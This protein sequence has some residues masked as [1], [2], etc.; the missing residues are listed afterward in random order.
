MKPSRYL[1]I[2]TS[3][4]LLLAVGLL[5]LRGFGVGLPA[6]ITQGFWACLALLVFVAVLDG[7]YSRKMPIAQVIRKFPHNFFVG[8]THQIAL[9]I[10]HNHATPWVI[11]LYDHYPN[12][13]R[14][15]DLPQT[16]KLM[17]GKVATIFYEVTPSVR[18]DDQFG[19][20]EQMFFS[21]LGL[22]H[23][24]KK[25]E[26]TKPVKVLPDFAQIMGAGITN[27]ERWMNLLGAKK[28]PRKGLGQDFHQLREY[29][30]EDTFRQIDW[31][32]TARKQSLVSREY[33][34]ERDQQIVFL[35]DCGRNMRAKDG[36]VSH[37]DCALNAMLLLTYTA[38]RHGDSVGVLT[39]SNE[40]PRFIRPG[41]G[42]AQLGHI[43][44]GL[45][46]VVPTTRTSDYA[47]AA[48][49][50]LSQQRRRALVIVLTNL[51]NEGEMELL[52]SLKHISRRHRLLI[53]SLKEEVLDRVSQTPVHDFDGAL[54]YAGA[55]S[56]L[57]DMNALYQ[58][59]HTHK[60]PFMSTHPR[61][62][63]GELISQ[64][65]KFKRDGL[66]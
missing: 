60:V 2:C 18:G 46:D 11:T 49:V 35:L 24:I 6:L 23:I 20:I 44:H 55:I 56:Y 7:Y 42:T 65:L 25:Q 64:Y 41:K 59:L 66:W 63:G 15:T 62:F 53:A 22:W 39:F 3:V 61:E 33:Q 4:L 29:R 27:L 19:A 12:T 1:L 10:H 17:P 52:S 57:R 38:L 13:W 58:K 9:E 34:D 48:D 5:F 37:F 16:L 31:K 45:Y 21:R 32:A 50:L 40:T 8:R 14:G 51:S 47:Q 43:V 54:S 30:D 36:D 28:M 26:A